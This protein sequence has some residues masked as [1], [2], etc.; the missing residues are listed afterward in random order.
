MEFCPE[1]GGML[2]P[3]NGKLKCGTCGYEK[4]VSS[5]K[6]E[7]KV[8]EKINS[9]DNVVDL[10]S[11]LDVRPTTNVLCPECG[12]NKAYFKLLQTRSADEAPTRIFTCVKCK[13]SW[14]EYD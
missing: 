10:G 9:K 14:R 8:S 12:H 4:D 7:Y 13:H 5:N 2:L 1:C 11:D 3:N 6:D